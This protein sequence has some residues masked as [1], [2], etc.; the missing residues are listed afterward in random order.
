METHS[1]KQI[2]KTLREPSFW[3][4]V[5][6]ALTCTDPGRFWTSKKHPDLLRVREEAFSS[7]LCEVLN[8]DVGS[9]LGDWH[10]TTEVWLKGTSDRCQDDPRAD[11]ALYRWDTFDR[12]ERGPSHREM[13]P[14]E[15]KWGGRNEGS[16]LSLLDFHLEYLEEN[17]GKQLKHYRDKSGFLVFG[18]WDNKCDQQIVSTRY[19]TLIYPQGKTLGIKF[20][21]YEREPY[22]GG[23]EILHLFVV[24][25]GNC[26][27]FD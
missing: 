17:N 21:R 1:R 6:E 27:Q 13:I 4:R 15:V 12:N 26:S 23:N 5:H 24:F 18:F 20:K 19:G 3:S 11:V 16:A 9:E 14:L 8:R 7:A 2:L 22:P 25:L 10:A